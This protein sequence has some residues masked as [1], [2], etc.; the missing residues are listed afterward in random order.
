MSDQATQTSS[1][2]APL[3]F[4]LSFLLIPLVWIGAVFG[5]WWILIAPLATWYLF[6]ALDLI[7]GQNTGNPDPQTDEAAL[8][9]YRI[10]T[11]IWVPKALSLFGLI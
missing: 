3:P 1:L 5:G 10:L 2:P 4:Y 6:S 9:W 11:Q 8:F 7:V